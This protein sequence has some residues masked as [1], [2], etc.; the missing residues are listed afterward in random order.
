[1]TCHNFIDTNRLIFVNSILNKHH[2]TAD[3]SALT[4][5]HEENQFGG[6]ENLCDN[7]ITD[8][9]CKVFKFCMVNGFGKVTQH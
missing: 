4:S 2:A 9:H 1:M 7:N 6:C 3:L 8:I 5:C